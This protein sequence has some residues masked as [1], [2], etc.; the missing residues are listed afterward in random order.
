MR[1][2]Q[3]AAQQIEATRNESLQLEANNEPNRIKIGAKDQYDVRLGDVLTF[4]SAFQESPYSGS[5][6]Q[7]FATPARGERV[8]W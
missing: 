4:A 2:R 7:L 8:W 1:R 3:S 5:N 6:T